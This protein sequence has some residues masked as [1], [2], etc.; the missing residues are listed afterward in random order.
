V[1]EELVR[2]VEIQV[3]G[4]WVRY[5]TNVLDPAG[6]P[7]EYMPLLYGERW[8]IEEAF[9]QVKRLLGLAYFWSGAENAIQMQVWATWLLYGVLVD[10]TDEVG[11]ALGL[12]LSALSLEMV[13][14]GLYHYAQAYEEDSRLELVGYLVGKAADLALVKARWYPPPRLPPLLGEEEK[15]AA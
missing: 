2:L 14:R 15:L 5:V 10:L 11:A 13:F 4:R 7:A 9:A 3:H 12:P 1:G 6:L 8:R